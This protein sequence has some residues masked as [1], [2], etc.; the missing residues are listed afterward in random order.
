MTARSDADRAASPSRLKVARR[1]R[2]LLPRGNDTLAALVALTVL[3]TVPVLIWPDTAPMTML[4][5]PLL[6]GSL[7]LGPR[8]LPWFVVFVMVMLMLAIA[9]Q[10]EITSKQVLA[11]TILYLLCFIVLLTS[12]RRSRLGV[13]GVQGESML[14]DLRDRIL[15]QGGIPPLPEGWLTETALRSAGGTPFAGDF[16]VAVGAPESDRLEI[17]VVDVSG[18]GE[19]AG[20]RALLLSGAFG[21]LLGA[22]PPA[23]FLPAAN[24][25]LLR[26]GWEE[27]FATAIHLS[28][29]LVSGAFEVRTAGH[30]PAAQLDAGSGRWT[31]HEGEGPVLGLIEEAEFTT[32][33]GVLRS[34]DALLLYTDGMVETPRREIG[35]GIDR[36]LGQAE[37]LLRGEFAG[38]AD[39]L[40]DSL[41][42]RNDDRALV[43]VHRR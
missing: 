14:V 22:L 33:A 7:L 23:D 36:M 19:Q 24:E 2:R 39:R 30:P 8:Q 20:T 37:R 6:L 34:G 13:A 29:D 9:A 26:Q 11:I 18:K 38:G 31:V 16:I 27:G 32:I 21:G 43:L 40:V 3:V 15:S 42:S 5:V 17:V 1:R 41:G 4:I 28:L 12:F 10:R 35:L 25:Y